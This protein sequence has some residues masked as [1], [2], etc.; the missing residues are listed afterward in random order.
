[1]SCCR[2]VKGEDVLSVVCFLLKW[3]VF[4][5]NTN[6]E[7]LIVRAGAYYLR[8]S[9]IG[10]T[11]TSCWLHYNNTRNMSCYNLPTNNVAFVSCVQKSKNLKYR[12]C[13]HKKKGGLSR[14]K[15]NFIMVF[16]KK[17]KRKEKQKQKV[18]G[19]FFFGQLQDFFKQ[20]KER[21]REHFRIDGLSLILFGLTCGLSIF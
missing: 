15:W 7:S 13:Y 5:K 9:F 3:H 20:K 17:K 1:M 6:D 4:S 2:Q 8:L 21:K 12:V 10:I 16:F 14:L 18:N 11:W 19:I